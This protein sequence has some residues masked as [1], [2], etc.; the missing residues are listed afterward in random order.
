MIKLISFANAALAWTAF[1]TFSRSNQITQ[2]Y[3]VYVV[4]VTSLLLCAALPFNFNKACSSF[5]LL[6]VGSE[7][8]SGAGSCWDCRQSRKVVR[9]VNYFLMTQSVQSLWKVDHVVNKINH[10]LSRQHSW[11]L[12][13]FLFRGLGLFFSTK[14]RI[15]HCFSS[16]LVWMYSKFELC[17]KQFWSVR[18]SF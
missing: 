11:Q 17:V 18:L 12:H 10:S 3:I 13:F 16:A 15:L 4:F 6:S 9:A 1:S 8:V 2:I 5:C 14:N 7:P